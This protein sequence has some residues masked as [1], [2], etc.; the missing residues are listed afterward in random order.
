[1]V[2]RIGWRVVFESCGVG[3]AA[4]QLPPSRIR[5]LHPFDEDEEGE[6]EEEEEEEDR[7]LTNTSY[8]SGQRV[9]LL[10]KGDIDIKE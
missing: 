5:Y 2:E 4:Y 6:E 8:L 3:R 10:K 9:V 7:Y 1:M